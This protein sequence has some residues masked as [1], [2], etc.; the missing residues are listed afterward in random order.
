MVA[1]VAGRPLSTA[2][3][4]DAALRIT[5][6]GIADASAARQDAAVSWMMIR[7]RVLLEAGRLGDA[8][9]EAEAV[10]T[11]SDWRER[12]TMADYTINFVL[13]RVAQYTGDQAALA[14]TESALTAMQHDD[15]GTVRRQGKWLAMIDAD[16][17]DHPDRALDVLTGYGGL[18]EDVGQTLTLDPADDPLFARIA[19]RAGRRDLAA[20]AAAYAERRAQENPNYPLLQAVAAH[21]RALVD[22]DPDA[23]AAAAEGFADIDR[24]LPRAEALADAGRVNP[25]R[26]ASIHLLDEAHDIFAK[27]GALR[28]AARTRQRLRALGA[29]RRQPTQAAG[30]DRLAGLTGP[31]AP[32][33]ISLPAAPPI[34]K[35]PSNCSYPRTPSAPTCATRSR[36]PACAHASNSPVLRPWAAVTSD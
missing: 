29:R 18:Y 10:A 5:D 6:Q 9:A 20:K 28:D 22:D 8:Q 24:P 21:T 30:S 19:G 2:G 14:R 16:A 11:L 3:S 12:G 35:S 33:W 15:V 4:T 32:S 31:N 26:D 27:A 1:A 25:N 36:R 7:S 34:A 23:L 13:R 17:N